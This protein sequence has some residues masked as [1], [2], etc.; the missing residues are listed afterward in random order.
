MSNRNRITHH[1][2]IQKREQHFPGDGLDQA[3][4]GHHHKR[5]EPHSKQKLILS[6]A[7]EIKSGHG[8]KPVRNGRDP[9][10]AIGRK[11]RVRAEAYDKTPD[12]AADAEKDASNPGIFLQIAVEKQEGR[13]IEQE[14][15]PRHMNKWMSEPSPPFAMPDRLGHE[16]QARIADTLKERPIERD[17]KDYE[18]GQ[19]NFL[20][21]LVA[22]RAE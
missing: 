19:L 3:F 5:T 4:A 18:P 15:P 9:A 10:Q 7:Y 2:E 1:S 13:A 6:M 12:G 17:E 14:M 20:P 8:H 11:H 16:H 22:A 21:K